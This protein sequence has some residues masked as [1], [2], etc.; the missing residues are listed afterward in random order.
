[1]AQGGASWPIG[2]MSNLGGLWPQ[3]ESLQGLQQSLQGLQQRLQG[4]QQV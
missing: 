2:P 3:S 1:M 4:L